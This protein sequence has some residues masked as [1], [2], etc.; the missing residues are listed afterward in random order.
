MIKLLSYLPEFHLCL[1][2]LH[3][4]AQR[5]FQHPLALQ[6]W[7]DKRPALQKQRIDSLKHFHFAGCTG[8][9]FLSQ[10]KNA[11]Q[12]RILNISPWFWQRVDP[13]LPS[14]VW[15]CWPPEPTL[16]CHPADRW[17]G[18]GPPQCWPWPP[19]HWETMSDHMNIVKEFMLYL[20]N[21]YLVTKLL[22]STTL[23]LEAAPS[24]PLFWASLRFSAT[25]LLFCRASF[26]RLFAAAAFQ[27]KQKP[28]KK[29]IWIKFPSTHI[30]KI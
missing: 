23:I 13:P 21:L 16:F 30:F 5:C 6:L 7:D 25:S 2:V 19:L 4:L 10:C 20:F 14:A 9:L 26:S 24:I 12:R 3:L 29:K 18:A 27:E 1:Q 11:E 8:H 17:G 28:L 22:G 15:D